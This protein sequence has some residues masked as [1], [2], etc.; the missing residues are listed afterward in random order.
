MTDTTPGGMVGPRLAS[1][2]GTA[3]RIGPALWFC[4]AASILMWLPNLADPMIRHD[5]FPALFGDAEDFWSKD[6]ERGTL[7][8]LSLA[9][10]RHLPAALVQL[11]SLC[12]HLGRVRC[13]DRDVV[14]RNRGET[15]FTVVLA[16]MI[17]ISTPMVAIS[18]W[19]NTLMPGLALVALYAVMACRLS[20]RAT[21]AWL[22]VFVVLTFLSYTTYP[23]LLL[24]VCLF[25]QE[26]RS[27]RNLVTVLAVFGLSFVAAVLVTYAIN[28]MVHGVFGI[29]LADWRQA[30]PADGVSGMLANLRS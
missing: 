28:W 6:A 16:L 9:S 22:P 11:R 27:L 7:A 12:R 30:T 23:L 8:Q 3:L 10:A 2:T 15:F 17:L 29:P 18:L 1:G 20:A 26:R 19:Y 13:R 24:A 21:L 5:D 25:R 4:L 14:T